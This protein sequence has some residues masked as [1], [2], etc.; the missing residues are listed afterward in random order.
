MLCI[1]LYSTHN[2]CQFHYTKMLYHHIYFSLFE[3]T[4]WMKHG[5]AVQYNSKTNYFLLLLLPLLL[6][7][8]FFFSLH[9]RKQF[10]L[11]QMVL[12]TM[13][14]MFHI[15]ANCTYSWCSVECGKQREKKWRVTG[16]GA[17]RMNTYFF[18][19]LFYIFLFI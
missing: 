6:L 19:K 5:T 17:S 9:P 13:Q 16:Q 12:R 4:W 2:V 14:Q 3:Y 11:G 1:H 15:F 18:D 10:L 7:L 8:F